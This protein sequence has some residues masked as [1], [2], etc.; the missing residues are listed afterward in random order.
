MKSEISFSFM[1]NIC[2]FEVLKWMLNAWHAD[3]NQFLACDDFSKFNEICYGWWSL[4]N[5]VT[6]V[7]FNRRLFHRRMRKLIR[8]HFMRLLF[9][10]SISMQSKWKMKTMNDLADSHISFGNYFE[11]KKR[12][13]KWWK[14]RLNQNQLVTNVIIIIIIESC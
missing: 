3:C 7:L 8:I 9:N 1:L 11:R 4:L 6:Y 14:N 5:N 12:E 2:L 10:F 13:K